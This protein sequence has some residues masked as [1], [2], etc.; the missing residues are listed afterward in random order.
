MASLI[1]GVGF[2]LAFSFSHVLAQGES[3]ATP[4]AEG[5][6]Y[7]VVRPNDSLW[8]IASHADITLQELLAFNNLRENSIIHPGDVLIIGFGTPP[9]TVTVVLPT[10]TPTATRP[11]PTPTQTT[12][13]PPRTAICL[14]AF[15]DLDR[16]GTFDAQESFKSAVAFTVFDE[17]SVVNNY[18][19]DGLSEPFCLEGLVPGEYKITR[20]VSRDETLTTV[21]DWS[22]TLAGGDVVNL[23]FGSYVGVEVASSSETTPPAPEFEAAAVD[24]A[25]TPESDSKVEK[26]V[27]RS[28]I[29]IVSLVVALVLVGGVGLFF[30]ARIR[31]SV[32]NK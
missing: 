22:L 30:F 19:S 5:I 17:E 12:V 28:S 29:L 21:G 8:A 2:T 27:G 9:P 4:D 32:F 31:D 1:L 13:P 23:E 11:P 14:M 15:D 18:I 3:T 6:I 25:I 16:D 24:G 10:S 20:S 26:E 7:V